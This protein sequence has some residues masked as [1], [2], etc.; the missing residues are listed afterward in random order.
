MTLECAVRAG[1]PVCIIFNHNSTMLPDDTYL[2]V[3]ISN[4]VV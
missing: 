4:Y 3:P 1:I 2:I